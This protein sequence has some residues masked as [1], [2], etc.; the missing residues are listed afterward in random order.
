MIET[1]SSLGKHVT[2]L[3]VSVGMCVMHAHVFLHGGS[4]NK[5]ATNLTIDA[6]LLE[7]A[8]GLGINLSATLEASLREAVR[9]RRAAQWLEDNRAALDG[10]NEWVA[11]NGLPLDKYRQ[12]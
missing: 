2:G 4:M 8:R 3:L 7:E 12:F 1:G 5:R 6:A 11:R 9:V 10:Y